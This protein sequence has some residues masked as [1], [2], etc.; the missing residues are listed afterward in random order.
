MGRHHGYGEGR[1]RCNQKSSDYHVNLLAFGF[2]WG[3]EQTGDYT[4]L[5][6]AL[7]SAKL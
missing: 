7:D 2:R 1:N 4:V 6:P 5:L 3:R